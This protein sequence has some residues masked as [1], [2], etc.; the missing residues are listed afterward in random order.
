VTTNP[1]FGGELIDQ[2][3]NRL[4]P[5]DTP[6]RHIAQVSGLGQNSRLSNVERA[7]KGP[8]SG[9]D[10]VLR[11]TSSAMNY[12]VYLQQQGL[13]R[14]LSGNASRDAFSRN[15]ISKVSAVTSAEFLDAWSNSDG[16][17]F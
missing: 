11:G 6:C 1:R 4:T 8:E 15:E 10:S 12:C 2:S 17:N 13:G 3:L 5:R 9:K 14:Q 16:L 7:S